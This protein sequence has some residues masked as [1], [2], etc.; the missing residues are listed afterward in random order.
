MNSNSHI[1]RAV[2]LA[3]AC[4][5]VS[6]FIFSSSAIAAY[7]N[8]AESSGT[9]NA[10]AQSTSAAPASTQLQA[11]SV[12]GTR[13]KRTDVVTSQPIQVITSAEIKSSG[14]AT[15]GQVL[16]R[17]TSSG[18]SLNAQSN[19]SGNFTYATTGGTNINLRFLGAN[20]TLVL[21][22]GHR[23]ATTLDGTV[24]LS[25]IPSS[26][27]DH[28][29]VLK[30]GASAIYG[31]EAIAGV[32]NIITVKNFSGAEVN[33]YT[34]VY[35]GDGH[36]DGLKTNDSITLGSSGAH[37]GFVLNA[38]YENQNAI[39]MNDRRISQEPAFNTGNTRGSTLTPQGR[40]LF[41]APYSGSTSDP[42]NVIAPSTGLTQAECPTQQFGT[43]KAPDYVPHCNITTITGT[44]GT[45]PAD[46]R[47]FTPNDKYNYSPH[48]YLFTPH[49]T[50]GLYAS[51]HFALADNLTLAVTAT[52]TQRRSVSQAAPTNTSITSTSDVKF[53]PGDPYYPFNFPISTS[54]TPDSGLLIQ[55]GKRLNEFGNRDYR[56]TNNLLHINTELRGFFD[57]GQSE[58]DWDAGFS[59]SRNN[60]LVTF[61]G[62]PNGSYLTIQTNPKLCQQF[63]KAG[64]VPINFFGGETAPMTPAQVDFSDYT[65]L[66]AYVT[67]QQDAYAD[68]TNSDIANLPAGPLGFAAGYERVSS[69]GSYTPDE[70][71]AHP[72]NSA[73]PSPPTSGGISNEAAYA[74][75]DVPLL[76]N[77]PLARLMNLDIA[78]RFTKAD[79]NGRQ[80]ATNTSSRAGLKWQPVHDLLVRAGWSQG[81]RSADNNE[82]FQAQTGTSLQAGDPCS[83]YTAPGTPAAVAQQCASQGVP[84]SYTQ[85]NDVFGTLT[86]GNPDLKPERSISK[87]IG[88][89]YSPSS[90]PGFNANLDY[91]HIKL[92]NSI[93]AIDGTAVLAA[94]YDQGIQSFCNQVVR[95][96]HTGV[97]IHVLDPLINI[98]GT[99]T[100][101]FDLGFTY[102]LPATSI[103][104][105]EVGLQSTYMNEY[106]QFLPNESGSGFVFINYLGRER[107]GTQFPL[108]MPRWKAN[109]N[110][111][112]TYGNWRVGW[113]IQYIGA[114]WESCS[115]YQDNTPTS[116][117]NLGL[118]SKPDYKN[119]NFS[120]N[121]LG[122]T[123]YHD[124]RLSYAFNSINTT[125]TFGIN[126]VFD[127]GPPAQES[128]EM[129]GY[130][131]SLY[132]IPGRF[133]YASV[134]VKF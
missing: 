85:I 14:L 11:V 39:S 42:N 81:F 8:Q 30:D 41:T 19:N 115:D 87:T 97:L 107:S 59:V 96:P 129:G 62:N 108:G 21:V 29:E 109:G 18:S 101:G 4:G 64:C 124:A 44:P 52:A 72:L 111:N 89:V 36:W 3:V 5:A 68:I 31:S 48:N 94:C 22:N 125:L 40:F 43:K 23:W 34:G 112:W 71:E 15:I 27:I 67:R 26:I 98:G 70:V 113:K 75:F 61:T 80:V 119:N 95:A 93:Q 82:L 1:S 134:G 38:S 45:G 78:S 28:I 66:N 9:A 20:R 50:L 60:L 103:G 47:P 133:Y 128:A 51:G 131:I 122:Q 56:Q 37:S 117:T 110:I 127:K 7:Q 54:G 83:S 65:S 74:E 92:T 77:V 79:V 102:N 10:P 105:F 100:S 17:V 130:D 6:G 63:V 76:A 99:I 132:R 73:T 120:Q 33:G 90:L 32:V 49:Q 12:T 121:H 114:L 91:Y 84:P 53:E 57:V 35:H 126:N 16:S 13:I 116:F 104:N 55:L 123:I 46:F 86:G 69:V 25:T 88:F 106:K 2:H 58:W 24:D 118:C